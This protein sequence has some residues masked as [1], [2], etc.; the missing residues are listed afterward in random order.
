MDQKSLESE[1]SIKVSNV[2]VTVN[3]I[4]CCITHKLWA[5]LVQAIIT[6]PQAVYTPY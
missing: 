6:L 1:V 4:N 5:V 3:Q 2:Y